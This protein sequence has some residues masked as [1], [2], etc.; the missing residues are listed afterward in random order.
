M[1]FLSAFGSPARQTREG[2]ENEKIAADRP[3]HCG[4]RIVGTIGC[5]GRGWSRDD[6]LPPRLRQANCLKKMGVEF[7]VE[8][9]ECLVM[10]V[11]SP[12]R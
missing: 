4:E 2:L 9:C 10:F 8:G 6:A 3:Y 5:S 1:S 12:R 11:G 7:R